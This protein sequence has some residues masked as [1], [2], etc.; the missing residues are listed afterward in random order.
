MIEI[1]SKSTIQVYLK[2]RGTKIKVRKKSVNVNEIIA[3]DVRPPIYKD[4]L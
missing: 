2:H 3:N 1:C 4:D